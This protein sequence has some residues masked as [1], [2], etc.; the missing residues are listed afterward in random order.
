[1]PIENAYFALVPFTVAALSGL[2]GWSTAHAFHFLAALAY[3][4]A[5]VFLFWFA[6]KLSGRLGASFA[7]ALLWSLISP[8]SVIPALYADMGSV[9][10]SRRLRN[11]VYYGEMPHVLA[12]CLL[13]VALWLLLRYWEKPGAR[14]F[15][16]AALA[17]AG[18]MLSNAFGIAAAVI[19][20]LALVAVLDGPRVK[21][22]VSLAGIGAGAYLVICRLLPPSLIAL[23]RVRS[24]LVGGDFRLT[25]VGGLMAALFLLGM[26]A[27]W[28][29]TRRIPNRILRF[30]ILMTACFSAITVIGYTTTLTFIA[31]PRRYMLEMDLAV[32]LL[33]AFALT[34]RKMS[35]PVIAAGLLLAAF[36]AWKD[37]QFSRR[38]IRP[39]DIAQSV[40]YRQARWI[41]EHLPGERVMVSGEY[42]F[43]FNLFA[44]N[45]QLS[46]GHEASAPNGM[47][48]I[49][50]YTI[51]SGQNLGEQDG[52]ISLMWLKAFGCGAI[53]V[54]G[55]GSADLYHPIRNP[56]KFD[57][58]LPLIWREGDD[59]IYR[60][61]LRSTSLAH[62]LPASAVVVRRPV[63]G[64][65]VEPLRPYIA[66]LEDPALPPAK[67][68][69]DNPERGRISAPVAAGQLLSLQITYDPGWRAA[70]GGRKLTIRRDALGMMT[71]DPQCTGNCTVDVEFTGGA[72]RTV[73]SVVSAVATVLLALMAL[74]GLRV[75]RLRRVPN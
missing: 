20:S 17:F 23:I 33:L 57:G 45:P 39:A 29:I 3:S 22:L 12:L 38:L 75:P 44:D 66:A 40:P 1:M 27:L 15:S 74:F 9:W 49:A 65:D 28:W 56:R 16:V 73:C 32:C 46:G 70:A 26:A 5:P 55:P 11:L 8:S 47:Q 71:I 50:V 64:G 52:P 43:W 68:Q 62:V 58:L 48:I 63:H 18:V 37:D 42:G 67:L 4:A 61:P 60:V 10:G 54:P 7:A 59:A 53:T 31:L 51:Y 69:W 24:Q 72:E 36:V 35:R 41:A 30:A 6:Y 21:M 14:R 34:P 13:P 25:A 19:T 2:T